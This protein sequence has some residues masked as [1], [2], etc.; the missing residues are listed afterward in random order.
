MPST[1][2]MGSLWCKTEMI[3]EKFQEKKKPK[4]CLLFMPKSHFKMTSAFFLH[5]SWNQLLHVQTV[6]GMKSDE[7]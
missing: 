7:K 5:E 6:T 4:P 1:D 3:G 2:T